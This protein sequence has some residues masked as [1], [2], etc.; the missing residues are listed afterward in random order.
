[1]SPRLRSHQNLNVTKTD[2]TPKLKYQQNWNVTKTE[3]SAK[4]DCST[5]HCEPGFMSAVLP[6]SW[7]TSC[8][9]KMRWSP[10]LTPDSRE[11]TVTD[12][13][14]YSFFGNPYC[15]RFKTKQNK[16]NKDCYIRT[17]WCKHFNLLFEFSK[18]MHSSFNCARESA[19]MCFTVSW[20]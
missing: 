9:P 12:E 6:S 15:C 4:L 17:V 2:K 8:G 11:F 19:D 14:K 7:V 13:N 18:R 1:M 10:L 5:G 3:M 20:G 16:T